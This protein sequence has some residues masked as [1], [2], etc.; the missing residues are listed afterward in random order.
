[1]RLKSF[2]AKTMSDAMKEVRDTLGEDAII[3]A[4]RE[5]PGGKAVSVTAAVDNDSYARHKETESR[6]QSF[7]EQ[8]EGGENQAGGQNKP[9]PGAE[10]DRPFAAGTQTQSGPHE[11]SDWLF[12]NELNEIH[13]PEDTDAIVEA[14]TDVMIRHGASSEVTDEILSCASVM[15]L[16]DARVSLVAALENLYEFRPLPTAA[17]GKSIMMIGPPG[18]GKTL[19][20]AKLAARGVMNGLNVG[21]ITTDVVRAGGLEQLQAFTKILDVELV[22]ASSPDDL[23]RKMA[24][25]ADM[26]QIIVDTGGTNPFEPE[27]MRELAQLISVGPADPV[28]VLPAGI[29]AHE[30]SDMARTFRAI[31]AKLLLPTRLDIARRLGGILTAAHQGG[32]KFADASNTARVADGL[33][34]INPRRLADY[35]MPQTKTSQKENAPEVTQQKRKTKAG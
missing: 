6:I 15:G 3:V 27:D 28:L 33:V 25:L 29:D 20:V 22:R 2:Y 34:E 24:Q 18:S 30:S 11:D 1:M 14:L 12:E 16:E 10:Y 9:K 23:T 32:L 7:L 21:V 17:S 13:E 19:A 31:G 8:V 26:D 5:E 4:T 35:L